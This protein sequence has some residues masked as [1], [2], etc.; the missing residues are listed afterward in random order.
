MKVEITGVS[1]WKSYG[2]RMGFY[3]YFKEAIKKEVLEEINKGM[4]VM[5]G[6][7]NYR[8]VLSQIISK[9]EKL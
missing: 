7:G 5:H 9:I 6:G 3:A 4:E 2:I 8:R 1:D